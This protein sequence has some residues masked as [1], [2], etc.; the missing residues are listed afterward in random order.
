[1]A[2]ITKERQVRY[3]AR[4]KGCNE[5]M[6]TLCTVFGYSVIQWGTMFL[7]KL[8]ECGVIGNYAIKCRKCN[9]G[10]HA[11]PVNG[12]FSAKHVCNAKCLASKSGI[13]ECSCGGKNHGASW[14]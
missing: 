4:C 3:I 13:C 6:S 7:D 11:K 10:R 8:G 2:T 9:R 14:G 5:T 12:K 1:M